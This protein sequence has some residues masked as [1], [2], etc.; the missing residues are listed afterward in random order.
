MTTTTFTLPAPGYPMLTR[1]IS[2]SLFPSEDGKQDPV[3]WVVSFP[4][5]LVP[6]MR[7]VRMFVDRGGVEVYSISA[8]GRNGMRN[9]IPM[10]MI[11]LVEEAMPINVFVDELETSEE[12]A[13]DDDDD[14]F[15]E[16]DEAPNP[17]PDSAPVPA[18]APDPN[19]D[20]APNGPAASS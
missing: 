16:E 6:E 10:S 19:A 13:S 20:S 12:S 5:P 11:R 2:N 8:D 18:P 4:H 1:M 17:E 9:L 14:G 15:D 3:T 7:V